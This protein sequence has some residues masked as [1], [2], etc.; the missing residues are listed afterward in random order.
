M[1]LT[2]S[3][4]G[5]RYPVGGDAVAV[6]N[7]LKNLALDTQASLPVLAA[8][9]PTSPVTGLVWYNTTNGQTQIYNGTTWQPVTAQPQA[10]TPTWTGV[11]LGNGTSTGSYQVTGKMMFVRAALAFGSTTSVTGTVSV[12]IPTG[13]TSAAAGDQ[14]IV[15]K[16]FSATGTQ[17]GLTYI[18]PGTTALRPY[19]PTSASSSVLQS[20]GSF[21]LTLNSTSIFS[22]QGSIEIA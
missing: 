18:G 16:V 19:I 12:N 3:P 11:T 1:G 22:V 21:A 7:D 10:Y 15:A 5:L 17:M 20:L 8:S 14:N 9:A 2:T 6:P 4:N 13:Y